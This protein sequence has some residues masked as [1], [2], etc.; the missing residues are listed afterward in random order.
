MLGNDPIM[1][2]SN[3]RR[4]KMSPKG[5][6]QLEELIEKHFGRAMC[7]LDHYDLLLM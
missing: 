3:H 1:L 5:R 2:A 7:Q 6:N 4:S